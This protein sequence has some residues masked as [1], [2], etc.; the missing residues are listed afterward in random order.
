VSLTYIPNT[1][2]P[3][4]T[5]SQ[6][7]SHTV[8]FPKSKDFYANKDFLIYYQRAKTLDNLGKYN[9]AL[10]FYLLSIELYPYFQLAHYNIGK[11][12]YIQKN[13][14]SCNKYL[15][16][17]III[18]PKNHKAY[19]LLGLSF[20]NMGK[21]L[22][23]IQYL[24]MAIRL[25]NNSAE[26]HFNLGVVLSEM[27]K[28]DL[29]KLSLI[30]VIDLNSRNY[31]EKAFHFLAVIFEMEEN[32]V[33]AI[34]CY[35]NLLY[36]SD[37]KSIYMSL[38]NLLR[39]L[40]NYEEALIVYNKYLLV[41]NNDI[42]ILI[43]KA[44]VLFELGRNNEAKK[45]YSIIKCLNP[46]NVEYY[47]KLA[48]VYFSE[49]NYKSSL[50]Y[51]YIALIFDT[52]NDSTLFKVGIIFMILQ[53]YEKAIEFFKL[54]LQVNSFNNKALFYLAE[55]Y[56]LKLDYKNSLHCLIKILSYGS[57]SFNNEVLLNLIQIKKKWRWSI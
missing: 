2:I 32:H 15:H 6:S 31:T 28:N 8:F 46:L 7:H 55:A 34:W 24:E 16:N 23:S 26:Y 5:Y 30:R 19:N 39:N 14:L 17:T 20:K 57:D 4:H 13:Y 44:E 37:D 21:F 35:K 45:V 18:N 41:N 1:H 47:L 3:S 52:N 51:L 53:Q 33:N 54:S 40:E 48:N 25:N 27:N 9:E 11:T 50:D 49:D 29:A 38:G 10:F 43:N 36:L 42:E 22:E 12:F 56:K